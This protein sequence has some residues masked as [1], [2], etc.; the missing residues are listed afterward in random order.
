M[1]SWAALKVLSAVT[2]GHGG[3]CEATPGVLCPVQRS[4]EQVL[5]TWTWWRESS[6]GPQGGMAGPSFI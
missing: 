3:T 6:E 4:Q 1:T 5:E 2:G